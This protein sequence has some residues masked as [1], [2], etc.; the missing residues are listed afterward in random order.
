[1][2][3]EVNGSVAEG[4]EGVECLFR[5]NMDRYAE[6]AAQLCVYFD[7]L[8]VVDLWAQDSA[9]HCFG[10]DSLVNVFSSG[11]SL[12]SL[13]VALLVQDGLL[14]YDEPIC[15][16]WPEF[17]AEGKT[18][19]TVADLMRHEAGITAL[20]V[21]LPAED[22]HRPNL[23]LNKIGAVVAAQQ[24]R[25]RSDGV[26]REYH[27]ITRGWILNE[28]VRRADP[29]GRTIGEL[30]EDKLSAPLSIDIKIGLQGRDL[31]RVMPITLMSAMRHFWCSL[32]PFQSR[33]RVH[34]SFIDL[35]RAQYAMLLF[36]RGRAY[37]NE[38]TPFL[39][40]SSMK[41]LVEYYNE[42]AIQCG[43]SSSTNT[44]ASARGLAK[45]AGM[46][47]CGGRM[48]GTDFF[49]RGAWDDMHTGSV[50]WEQ[51]FSTSFTR[52]GLNAFGAS[53]VDTFMDKTASKGREGF[54]GWMGLGGSLFQWHPEL[55]IGIGFVPTLLHGLDFANERSKTYQAEAMNCVRAL[56]E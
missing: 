32:Q 52:S 8:K 50:T 15:S 3:I 13:I 14:A 21:S 11:K 36:H 34:A 55:R 18:E 31:G 53:S 1:M 33:R 22:L 6:D 43:E 30:L 27:M 45:L 28:V 44:H 4:F 51:P 5:K 26:R 37:K 12:E 41:E 56:T 35:I 20:D 49:G 48:D 19:I 24:P 2:A 25:F 42:P 23:K 10:P 29:Q 54:Y 17:G 7:G 38:P 16:Y 39:G 47:A 9:D 40:K 46:M